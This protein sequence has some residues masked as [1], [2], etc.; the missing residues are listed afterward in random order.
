MDRNLDF[1]QGALLFVT[2]EGITSVNKLFMV[3]YSSLSTFIGQ[4]FTI[5]HQH[6][7]EEKNN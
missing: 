5:Q 6:E 4:M 7:I 3:G 2:S 1:F